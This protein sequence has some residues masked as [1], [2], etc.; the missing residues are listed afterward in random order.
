MAPFALVQDLGK[1][2]AYAIYLLIGVAF[3]ITLEVAGFA[4]S[5]KLANQ[6]YLRDMTVLKVMFTGIITA[7]V[8]IFLTSA[9]GL[10]SYN[11]IYVNPTYL[12][13]G[14]VGGLIMG[15]GFILGGFCPGTSLVALASLKVDGWFFFFGTLVGVFLFGESVSQFNDFFHSSYMG[16]FILP[17]WLGI[18]TG[19]T[20]VL[21]V[22]AALVA[23]WLAEKAEAAF[24]PGRSDAQP[25]GGGLRL[26]SIGGLVVL[27]L[28]VMG[29]GQPSPAKKWG[30]IAEDKAPLLENREVQIHPGELI[31]IAS[32]WTYK[33]LI[34]DVRSERDYNLFHLLDSR[35][36]PLEDLAAGS[37]TKELLDEPPNAIIV[38]VSNDEAAATE[39][40]KY[41]T[42][43]GIMNVYLLGGGIN[44]WLDAFA[45]DGACDGCRPMEAGRAGEE[46]P[47]RWSF[48]EALGA[49][50]PIANLDLFRD[51]S[52]FFVP[53]VKMEVKA[54]PAG[55]CG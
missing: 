55:G 25:M 33:L 40:W 20:V 17:E 50:R 39:G 37:L 53:K 42:A 5:R 23:F 31:Q 47:L 49:N 28:A 22:L 1:V 46:E 52:M 29:M 35:R 4:N 2:G 8:L 44:G 18:S 9:V 10:L 30:F 27:A 12:W 51:K 48:E 32:N 11:D 13:P 38:L 15:V 16:R 21:I 43:E 45:G 54:R 6:F 24:G 41:L 14:I 34:L 36:V 3:G 19:A 7:M 26:A